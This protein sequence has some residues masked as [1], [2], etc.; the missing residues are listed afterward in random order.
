MSAR[1]ARPESRRLDPNM[2]VRRARCT[3]GY[4]T[5]A[6]GTCASPVSSKTKERGRFVTGR[7]SV[8]AFAQGCE[9]VDQSIG[10]SRLP[11]PLAIPVWVGLR[12]CAA[13]AIASIS[14]S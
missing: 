5:A 2:P 9:K 12:D 4:R 8:G 14:T 7:L 13:T 1:F 10:W 6:N 11:T 3:H